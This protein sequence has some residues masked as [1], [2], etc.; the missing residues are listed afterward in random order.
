MKAV[1]TLFTLLIAMLMTA[2]PQP[3]PTIEVS[4][5]GT[6]SVVPDRVTI[7]VSVQNEG[8]DPKTLKQQNDATVSEVL[9]F[10]KGQNIPS[11]NITTQFVQLNKNYDYNTKKYKYSASQT[12]SVLLEDMSKYEKVMTGLVNSGVNRIG[13]ISFGTSKKDELEAEARRLAILDAKQ[14]ATEYV[15]P[16]GQSVGKAV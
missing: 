10:L 5:E 9:Q 12:I 15:K 16:L 7:S 13:G 8:Q 3:Q 2:Q 4:G 11:K 6:V 1:T 14:K